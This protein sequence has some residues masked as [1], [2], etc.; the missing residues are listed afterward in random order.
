MGIVYFVQSHDA[1]AQLVRLLECLRAPARGSLVIVGH[2]GTRQRLARADLPAGDDVVLRQRTEPVRRGELSCLEPYL[3]AAAWLVDEGLDFDWLVYLSGRDYP[4]R[5]VAA[6]EQ[7]LAATPEDGYLRHWDVASSASPWGT[8]RAHRRY[9][10]RY[11][12]LP[13][14]WRWPLKLA[15]PV[16]R[17]LGLELS[18]VYGVHL[19]TPARPPLFTADFRCFGGLQWH[20]LRRA[21]VEYLVHVTRT[22]PELVEYFAHTLVPDEAYVQTVLLNAGRFRFRD[23]SR[24]FADTHERPGGHCRVLTESDFDELT[25]GRYDF[26]RRFDLVESA[27][28]LRRL[29]GAR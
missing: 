11:R 4:V 25:S 24:R 5:P 19:G 16:L 2:E 22:R 1:V 10:Y 7:T 14:P 17:G 26:A 12:R 18:L 8:K 28:L 9:D 15:K 6:I 3:D 27:E 21:P 20:A 29:E 13:E 23:E